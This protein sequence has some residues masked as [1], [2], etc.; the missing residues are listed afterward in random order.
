[1]CHLVR[2]NTFKHIFAFWRENEPGL[3]RL[4]DDTL[5]VLYSDQLACGRRW[6]SKFSR[7]RSSMRSAR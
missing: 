3:V 1:M 7:T 4:E 2:E 5:K 6:S